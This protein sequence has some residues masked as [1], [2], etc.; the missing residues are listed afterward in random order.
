MKKTALTLLS[1]IL[2]IS[3]GN[4]KKTTEITERQKTLDIINKVNKYWQTQ[5]PTH[6]DSFWHRAA[7]HVG[8][9]EAFKATQDSTYLQYTLEWADQ[10]EWKG[11][12]RMIRSN[13]NIH[14]A[15]QMNMFSLGIFKR[16]FKYML[17]YIT[18]IRN[19]TK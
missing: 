18:W 17:T 8:N 6:G 19:L 12:N 15:R 14:M 16:V 13:G 11:L 1:V 3:C 9:M 5:N 4:Q 7:Y 2:L 10:N